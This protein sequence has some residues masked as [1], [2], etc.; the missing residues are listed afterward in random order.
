M[1]TRHHAKDTGK[2]KKEGMGQEQNLIG[3]IEREPWR[4]LSMLDPSLGFIFRFLFILQLLPSR[5]VKK[6][7]NKINKGD[8]HNTQQRILTITSCLEKR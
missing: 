6:K 8:L 2:R 7:N 4:L 3:L 1:C 5:W